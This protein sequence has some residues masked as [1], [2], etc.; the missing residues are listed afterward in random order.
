MGGF[1]GRGDRPAVV[2]LADL[3]DPE[4][5]LPLTGDA[6]NASVGVRSEFGLYPSS[7]YVQMKAYF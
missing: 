7:V 5:G 1:I 6:L 2:D 3:L 4:T